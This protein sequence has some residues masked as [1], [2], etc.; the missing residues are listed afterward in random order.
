MDVNPKTQ[1]YEAILHVY[2]TCIYYMYK[3]HVYITCIYYIYILHVYITCIYYM[4]IMNSLGV[5]DAQS[6]NDKT[7]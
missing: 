4:Y 2:I 5:Q 3:L 6:S 7:V 1:S